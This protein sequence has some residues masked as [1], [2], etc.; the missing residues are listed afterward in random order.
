MRS[1]PVNSVLLLP[2]LFQQLYLATGGDPTTDETTTPPNSEVP[3]TPPSS[4]SLAE[5]VACAGNGGPILCSDAGS[6][7]TEQLC[8]VCHYFPLSRALLPC[9]HTCIC[10][11]CFCEYPLQ[12]DCASSNK[13]HSPFP[14]FTAKLERCP[15][16]RSPITSYFCIRSE[17]YLP[18]NFI[19]SRSNKTKSHG[20]H[21]LDALNDRLTDFLGFR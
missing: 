6:P 10:A 20:A 14:P 2:P 1:E 15:M 18:A 21:W 17:E 5:P 13:L 19:E 11:V 7:Q 4:L 8:V 16:C 9:R 12:S 3:I